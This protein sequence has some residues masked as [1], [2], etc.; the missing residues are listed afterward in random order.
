MKKKLCLFLA[1]LVSVCLLSGCGGLVFLK[2]AD[3]PSAAKSAEEQK[4]GRRFA[5]ISFILGKQGE[6]SAKN[7]KKI[8]DLHKFRVGMNLA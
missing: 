6:N 1:C 2:G 7:K 3:G 5:E 4:D 8:G